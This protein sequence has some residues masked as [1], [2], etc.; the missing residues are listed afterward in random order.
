MTTLWLSLL[1]AAV[2]LLYAS[3][4]QAGGS[5][6]LA[7]MAL[8]GVS[9]EVMKPTALVLNVL[10]ATIAMLKFS[11]A[12]Y[13]SWATFWPFAVTSVP[14]AFVGG[15]LS[16]STAVYNMIVGGV[17]LYAAFRLFRLTQAAPPTCITPPPLGVAL[18]SGVG[19]GLLSG[20]TGIGGG[21]VFGPLLLS[22]RWAE[23]R[24]TLGMSAAINLTNSAAGLLGHLASVMALPS[25]IP[26]W[27]AAAMIGGWVGAEYGGRRFS[28]LT[29][30]RLLSVVLTIAALKLILM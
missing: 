8:L 10:V 9:P 4:G 13:F 28:H 17:L 23:T 5:G 19:V 3:V 1:I 18:I 6:Y 29:L 27:A 16:F 11:H 14:A 21:I 15:A 2:S 20:F 22:M 25:A 12:G 7:V 26:L 24:Q 30:Q